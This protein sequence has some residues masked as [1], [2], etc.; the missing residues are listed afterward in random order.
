MKM[1]KTK[2]KTTKKIVSKKESVKKKII[3][4]K[5]PVSTKLSAQLIDVKGKSIGLIAL[6]REI[7]GQKPNE[8]LLAQAIRVYRENSYRR[9]ASTKTRGEKRG[10]GAKPWRQ[11]GTGRARA[12]SNRSPLWVGGGIT[13]GPKHRDISLSLPKKMKKKALIS[14]LSKK[15]SQGSI[16]VISNI[17]KLTPKTKDTSTLL[18]NSQL[19]GK[20]LFI[21]ESTLKNLNLATRNIPKVSNEIVD[22]LNAYQISQFKNLLFTKGAIEKIK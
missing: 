13:F 6:N 3:S 11:K 9:T 17:E 20:T 8:T 2:A 1:P 7:F 15:N 16:K 12:G 21:S 14:A 4:A 10:G 22:N 18:K 5:K 19:D